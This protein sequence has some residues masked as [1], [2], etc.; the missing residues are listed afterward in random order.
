MTTE[1]F[2]AALAQFDAAIATATTAMACYKVLQ[3]LTEQIVGVKLF[4]V[5]T[6]DM[7]AEL[8]RRAYTSDAA[9]YPA[10][11][12]KPI[13]YDDWFEIVHK[14][15]SH[16]VANTLADIA[17]VFPDYEL[18]GSLGCGSVVNLPVI[19]GD[20]LLATVNMLHEEQYFT[21]ERVDLITKYLSI[22]AKAA[23]LA[24]LRLGK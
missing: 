22:P 7:T 20:E 4:T 14:K 5:M 16:F 19:A 2:D 8:A 1:N 11:G 9:N 24:A 12:T 23:H 17:K 13:T 18:I 6:V 10:S 3:T 15:R 21:P